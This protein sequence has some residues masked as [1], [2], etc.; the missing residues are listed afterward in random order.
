MQE[1]FK[2]LDP[3]ERKV[4]VSGAIVLLLVSIYFLGWEPVTKKVEKLKKTNVENQQTLAWMKLHAAEV[5]QLRGS[6]AGAK[7]D[8]KGQSLMGVLDKTAKSNQ[9]GSAIK[10]V[11]PDGQTKA[12]VRLEKANFNKLL[13][14][15][16]QLQLRQGIVVTNSVI[17]KQET[18][19]LVNA[20]ITFQV[21]G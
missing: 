15:M 13:R 12:L 17:E 6:S 14:W 3:R 2:S 9:L 16:E 18:P 1:W 11:Q 5:K 8:L 10:R 20:R 7:K 19:G 4:I 21:S